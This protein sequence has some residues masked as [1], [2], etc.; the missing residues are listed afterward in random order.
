LTY[1]YDAS[2]RRIEK[3]YDG[4]TQVKYVYDGDSCIAE[5]DGSGTLL[6]KY[7]YG[8]GI[9]QPVSM[10]ESAGSYAG[11]YYYHF[12][13]SNNVVA[14]TNSSG[15]TVEVYEY[16]VYGKVGA[17][18]ASHPNRFMFTGREFDKETG[19]YYYRARYYKAEIGRFL[20]ADSVGYEAGM[21]LYRYCNNNPWNLLDPL[22]SDPCEPCEP[23]E[24][25]QP[26]E[27]CAPAPPPCGCGD[28]ASAAAAGDSASDAAAGASALAV[29]A[30]PLELPVWGVG[31]RLVTSVGWGAAFYYIPPASYRL[32]HR[33]GESIPDSWL[34]PAAG[35]YARLLYWASSRHHRHTGRPI[36][37]SERIDYDHPHGGMKPHRHWLEDHRGRKQP[38]VGPYPPQ[39]DDPIV[40]PAPDPPVP[41]PCP[42]CP[43]GGGS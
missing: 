29:A 26:S 18:D 42:P 14:L 1:V 34:M 43:E 28:S 31:G 39:P 13:G 23:C 3:K 30:P 35:A 27:P 22:G 12:D 37:G 7:I 8:P 6:R 24:P 16:D 2:G 5:Y 17:S 25:C 11:T 40:P 38:R 15:N 21:N 19:L 20:Q 36:P 33:V 9:D 4:N 41:P 10:I 32:G